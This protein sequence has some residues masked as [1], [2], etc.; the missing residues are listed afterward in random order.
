VRSLSLLL[1]AQINAQEAGEV[2]VFLIRITHPVLAAPELLST[3]PTE[4][5]SVTPLIYGTRSR[6]EE[7]RFLPMTLPLP[8]EKDDA[9]PMVRLVLDNVGRELV[10]LLRSS[11]IPA[12]FRIELVLA[13]APDDIEVELP[14]LEMVAADYDDGQITLTL[15]LNGLTTEPFPYL[16]F[17]PATFPGLF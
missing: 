17:S 14:L 12:L 16:T 8:D 11:T 2:P 15:T 1:R 5:L 6:G 7:Y 3:D 13:S 9:T 10:N 4:R